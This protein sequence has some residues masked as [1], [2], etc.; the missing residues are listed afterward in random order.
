M[1]R[2][3]ATMTDRAGDAMSHDRG[4]SQTEGPGASEETFRTGGGLIATAFGLTDIGV[5][6]AINQDTLGNR[7][8]QYADRA[9]NLGLLYAI[10]D[11][12]GGHAHGEVASALAIQHLFATYYGS[13]YQG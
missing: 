9:T 8:G 2:G 1:S 11:G 13:D 6:R 10:A 4:Q 7:V 3:A 12:M 5:Q